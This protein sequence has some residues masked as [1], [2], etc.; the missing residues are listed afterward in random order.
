MLIP[1]P[2]LLRFLYSSPFYEGDLT[3]GDIMFVYLSSLNISWKKWR[4][5]MKTDMNI[6]PVEG[7]RNLY[8][9]SYHCCQHGGSVNSWG[10]SAFLTV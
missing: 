9:I 8:L 3:Y 7:H 1:Y 4:I 2:Y 6:L 5:L 10:A